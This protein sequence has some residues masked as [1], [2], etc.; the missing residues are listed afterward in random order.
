M[1]LSRTQMLLS[2]TSGGKN[3]SC[4]NG[5][6]A[7]APDCTHTPEAGSVSEVV[8]LVVLEH[9]ELRAQ[10]KE[11]STRIRNLRIAVKTLQN[12][13]GK[14]T[15]ILR[16]EEN[17]PPKI[18]RHDLETGEKRPADQTPDT[19]AGHY[20]STALR[21]AVRVAICETFDAFSNDEIHA[22]ILRR[23]SFS[24]ADHDLAAQAITEE[25]NALVALGELLL[26]HTAI[27][28][29]WQRIRE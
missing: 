5:D 20:Q 14:R 27:G 8:K 18:G 28:H 2:P 11:V 13:R 21:R 3:K 15:G 1:R 19:S 9:R 10:Y 6:V 4:Q 22:R 29:G 23:G 17:C 12:L 7:M 24:F 25:L 16:Q 26:V